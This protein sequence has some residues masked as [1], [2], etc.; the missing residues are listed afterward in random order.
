MA[1]RVPLI[2]NTTAQQIQE[3]GSG[4]GLDLSGSQL[5]TGIMSATAYST[6]D[7]V[8]SS[9]TLDNP[10]YNYMQVGPITVGVGATIA[11]GSGVSYVVI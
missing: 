10:D 9:I 11:V 1:D 7:S 4:D 8:T 6:P 5:N 2:F 3:L